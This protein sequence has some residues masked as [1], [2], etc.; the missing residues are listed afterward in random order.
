[1]ITKRIDYELDRRIIRS[2]LDNSEMWW[3]GFKGEKVNNWNI[4]INTN[5]LTTALLTIDN[6]NVRYEVIE[7]AIKS[8][9]MFL[10]G[11]PN[12]GGCD[13]GPT[14]W[15]Q[16]GG[17]L[18]EFIDLLSSFTDKV[19]DWSSNRFIHSIGS[20]VYKMHI[21]YNR[22]VNFGDSFPIYRPDPIKV[23]KFGI[24]FNDQTM[25]EF[26]SYLYNLD[27]DDDSFYDSSISESISEFFNRVTFHTILTTMPSKAPLMAESWLPDLQIITLRSQEGSAEGLF[28]GAKAGNNG[29]LQ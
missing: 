20:Y 22:F 2:F 13:E 1:M 5:V 10:N 4:W 27:F 28:L 19:L 21:D 11:Y 9:D 18:I 25:I 16:A 7:K 24:L 3:M 23:L 8:A 29:T 12:D 17:K 6:Q 15:V 14:Y 26:A